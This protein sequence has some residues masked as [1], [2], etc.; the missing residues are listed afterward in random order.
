MSYLKIKKRK[1]K[2]KKYDGKSKHHTAMGQPVQPG[3]QAVVTSSGVLRIPRGITVGSARLPDDL[4]AL[5]LD[6]LKPAIVKVTPK[7][8]ETPIVGPPAKVSKDELV[9]QLKDATSTEKADLMKLSI[10]AVSEGRRFV[11]NIFIY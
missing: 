2:S 10:M 6:Y 7:D 5:S 3:S 9:K 4:S 8:V 1:R 11:K